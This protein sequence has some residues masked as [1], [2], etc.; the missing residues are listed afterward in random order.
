MA[1]CSLPETFI[2]VPDAAKLLGTAA[3]KL[4]Q[5]L[6]AGTFPIGVAFKGAG[7][8]E[9]W[10]YRIPREPFM[11]FLRTGVVPKEE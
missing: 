3:V 1:N 4:M 10:V 6:R 8:D 2:S 7:K 11:K 9:R 5:A